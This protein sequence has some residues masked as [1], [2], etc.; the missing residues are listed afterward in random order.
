MLGSVEERLAGGGHERR[1][2]LVEA[3]VADDHD[4]DLHAV[5]VLDLGGHR[6]QGA[7]HRQRLRV[8][9]PEQPSPEVAL[10]APCERLDLG[11]IVGAA[12]DQ[13]ERLEDGIVDCAGEL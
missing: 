1:A 6:A 7:R 4:V 8:R 10:L 9:A 3:G 12:L 11:R 5:G 2:V 13:G